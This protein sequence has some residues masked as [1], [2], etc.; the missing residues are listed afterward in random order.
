MSSQKL[1]GKRDRS[2]ICVM[3]RRYKEIRCGTHRRTYMC[4]PVNV[5][6]NKTIIVY[7]MKRER[8]RQIQEILLETVS[9]TVFEAMAVWVVEIANTAFS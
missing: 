4:I 8:K 3:K 6:M 5:F 7:N 2:K 1:H 9:I